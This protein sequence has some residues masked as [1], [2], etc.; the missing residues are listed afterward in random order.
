M[1]DIMM[2][3]V[4]LY[5]G[6][7]VS[8]FC[9]LTTSDLDFEQRTISINKQ[10]LRRNDGSRYIQRMTKTKAGMRTLFMSDAVS[11]S[12][13]NMI[14]E[15]EKQ[16]VS[17][18]IDQC[19]GFLMLT[20][21]GNP[22]VACNLEVP[23]KKAV[24]KYNAEHPE[25]LLPRITPHIFRHTFCSNMLNDGVSLPNTQAMMGHENP[26][27]TLTYAHPDATQAMAEMARINRQR[28]QARAS[29]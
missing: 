12:L 26:N 11:E 24:T 18:M 4:L 1:H 8:E 9:G 3:V 5:T 29:V 22:V 10:L 28:E 20:R 13:H 21:Q 2:C 23:L 19:G 16:K 7:R 15:R 17:P 6:M 25:K 27:T 14:R